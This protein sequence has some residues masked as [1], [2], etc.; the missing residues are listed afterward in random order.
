MNQELHVY[1]ICLV[2]WSEF[3]VKLWVKLKC[4][5]AHLERM[6]EKERDSSLHS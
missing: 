6:W 1:S 4:T 5:W 3:K 2:A